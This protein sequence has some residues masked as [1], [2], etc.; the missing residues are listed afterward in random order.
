MTSLDTQAR[1]WL[2]DENLAHLLPDPH[3]HEDIREW[4]GAYYP[5]GTRA[6]LAHHGFAQPPRRKSSKPRKPRHKLSEAEK[7]MA[8]KRVEA[9]EEQKHV[10][11]SV[12]CSPR[13]LREWLAKARQEALI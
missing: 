12:R 1:A 9:G 4:I 8:I 11:E 5:G 3:S 6:F 10:A 2:E 13:A 7:L